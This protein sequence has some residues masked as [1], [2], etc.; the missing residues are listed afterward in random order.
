MSALG[1]S[2]SA[3]S[4]TSGLRRVLVA[5]GLYDLVEFSAW[6]AIIL[7]AYAE[8]GATLA[9]VVAVVQL[10]PASLLAPMLSGF[11]DRLPR[12]AALVLAH[13]IVAASTALTLT[14][15]VLEAPVPIVIL[16]STTTT[17][18]VAI[19][20]PIHFAALPQLARTAKE[21]VSANSLSSMLDGI[22]L[23]VGPALAGIA[24]AASGPW[25]VFLGAFVAA[26]AAA[27]LCLRLHL[28]AGVN[29]DD[30]DEPTGWRVALRGVQ[31][32]WGDWAAL[33]LLL[34]MTITFVLGGAAD[35][36]G[37]PYAVEALGLGDSAAGL[38]IGASGIG[39]LIGAVVAASLLTRAGSSRIVVLGGVIEGAGFAAVALVGSLIPAMA[40]L[41]LSGIG[42][43]LLLVSGR[44]LL[45]RTTDDGVLARVFAVQ[46]AT[47]LLGLALGAALV[48]VFV[49]WT[50]AGTAFAIFGAGAVT[51]ALAAFLLVRQLDARAD[52]RPRAVSLLRPLPTFAGLPPYELERMAGRSAWLDVA[53]G[54]YVI[55]QG[56]KGTTFYAI[57]EAVLRCRERRAPPRFLMAG[58]SF[59]RSPFCTMF[60]APRRSSPRPMAAPRDHVVR[61]PDSRDRQRRSPRPRHG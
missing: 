26:S 43:A 45:Q 10:L 61:L 56:E 2:M 39:A 13:A 49:S 8:G 40:F 25:L 55:T 57:A 5:Y 17:V 4:S 46:E 33:S 21:L 1:A 22:G 48:P 19:V 20:R 31:T 36:L 50:S 44:T 47:S 7:Y 18:A 58:Q 3:L 6:V 27:V 60:L 54:Q 34:V 16:A 29:P 51:L 23:F 28:D 24:V 12:G 32:L 30:D 53:A 14:A 42:G 35:V 41:L 9:G 52:L 37:A 59:G 15:L 11:G 38:V